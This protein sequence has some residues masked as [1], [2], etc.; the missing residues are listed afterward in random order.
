MR[1]VSIPFLLLLTLIGAAGC[2]G[3]Q[4]VKSGG[5][6]VGLASFYADS[7]AGNLTASGEPYDPSARTCAHRSH[8]FGTRLKV[9][10]LRSGRSIVCRVNDRGPFVRGRIIDLS[11]RSAKELGMVQAGVVKVRVQKL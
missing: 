5:G 4:K 7:L 2:A 9:T 10:A 3:K 6:Q 8:A 11:R 1:S